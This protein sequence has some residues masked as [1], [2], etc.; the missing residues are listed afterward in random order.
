[1]TL[2]S[3]HTLS[4]VS[5]PAVQGGVSPTEEPAGV[6]QADGEPEPQAVPQGMVK[7]GEASSGSEGDTPFDDE[8]GLLMGLE[9]FGEYLLHSDGSI[10]GQ[11]IYDPP[12]TALQ[13]SHMHTTMLAA[14]GAN[15]AINS[16]APPTEFLFL[17]HDSWLQ[18]QQL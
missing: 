13:H 3:L 15:I 14:K 2:N 6:P 8:D 9:W 4:Q 18:Q 10:A 5:V 16:L 17:Q 1:M 7:R 12:S 11:H